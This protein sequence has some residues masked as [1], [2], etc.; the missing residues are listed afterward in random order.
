MSRP[1]FNF[2]IE[3]L[4]VAEECRTASRLGSAN[5][6]QIAVHRGCRHYAPLLPPES[7]TVGESDLPH[8]VLG[9]A[10]LCGPQDATT[11]QS[12]RC[13]SMVLSDLGNHPDTIRVAAEFFGVA[14]RLA[15]IARL[16]LQF[17][18]HPIH[19]KTLLVNLPSFPNE[20]DFLPGLSRLTS[21]TR[22]TRFGRRPVRAWL[23]TQWAR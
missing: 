13:G 19:W 3:E 21:E 5:L 15:H 22:F 12:I 11:F 8:E 4:D 20:E 1:F 17:D 18:A 2:A 14:N 6:M 23:R 16:G 9:T 7:L 10:L